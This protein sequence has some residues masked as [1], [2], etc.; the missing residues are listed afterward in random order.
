MKD[1]HQVED[2]EHHVEE[3]EHQWRR[4]SISGGR[5]ESGGGG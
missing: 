1:E 3:D 2:D 4:M 5:G